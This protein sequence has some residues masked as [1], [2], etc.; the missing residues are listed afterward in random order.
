MDLTKRII[1]LFFWAVYVHENRI[2]EYNKPQFHLK[3]IG[4]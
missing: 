2:R 4:V 1:P 3:Q